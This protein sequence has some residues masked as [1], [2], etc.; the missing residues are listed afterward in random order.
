MRLWTFVTKKK[1][2]P[3]L[4]WGVH[5]DVV[6]S[7]LQMRHMC[8]DDKRTRRRPCLAMEFAI[9]QTNKTTV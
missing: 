9:M 3:G 6:N 4:R 5:A 2:S 7:L 1:G 8:R